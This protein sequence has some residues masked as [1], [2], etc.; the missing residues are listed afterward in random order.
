MVTSR[1]QEK[2]TIEW[3]RFPQIVSRQVWSI[4]YRAKVETVRRNVAGK[5]LIRN[6]T[7][8]CLSTN[9]NA[10]S[11]TA[12]STDSTASFPHRNTPNWQ[13]A[14]PIPPCGTSSFCS[15]REFSFKTMAVDVARVTDSPFTHSLQATAPTPHRHGHHPHSRTIVSLRQDPRV[16][17]A[18]CK[19][20][21]LDRSSPAW[22]NECIQPTCP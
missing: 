5:H 2:F 15:I 21:W 11:S 4:K 10:R 22:T 17:A 19:S 9:G 6:P 14:R 8:G 16:P 3:G 1:Q 12:C 7:A 18:F 13:N 20:G